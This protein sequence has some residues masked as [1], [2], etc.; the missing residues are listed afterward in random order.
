ML[1]LNVAIAFA[2]SFL[3][4]LVC[5]FNYDWLAIFVYMLHFIYHFKY[6]RRQQNGNSPSFCH[7]LN[8]LSS[9]LCTF[10]FPCVT[11]CFN[12]N[13][14]WQLHTKE[15]WEVSIDLFR[16]FLI[17]SHY[18]MMVLTCSKLKVTYSSVNYCQLYQVY[19]NQCSHATV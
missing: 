5:K 14:F 12:R 3:F 7:F 18:F 13:S 10:S 6:C 9:K 8:M 15:P 16:H 2:Q 19:I 17:I 1:T 4:K 11:Y